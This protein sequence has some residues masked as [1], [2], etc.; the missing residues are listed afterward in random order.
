LFDGLRRYRKEQGRTLAKF[1]SEYLTDG[2]LVRIVGGDGTE[3]YVPLVRDPQAMKYD[4][5]V[6]EATASVNQKERTFALLMQMLPNLQQMGLPFAP[7]LLE[8]S[9]LPAAMVDK[10]KQ[11][12]AERPQMDPRMVQQLQQANAQLQQQ[13]QQATMRLQN[14]DAEIAAKMR[15]AQLKSDTDLTAALQKAQMDAQAD[16]ATAVQKAQLD[17]RTA[18]EKAVIDAQA[19]VAIAEVTAAATPQPAPTV[20]QMPDQKELGALP[21]ALEQLAQAMQQIMVSHEQIAGQLQEAGRRPK[22]VQHKRD[23]NGLLIE[24]IPEF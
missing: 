20:V 21:G 17:A 1:I 14:K 8:Y 10:W 4:V 24:S 11:V 6:D 9:P 22:R 3:R 7:E 23:A 18:I 16:Y 15:E 12:I 13:L 5:I 19:K 2:R